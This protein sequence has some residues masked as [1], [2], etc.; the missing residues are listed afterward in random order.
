[1]IEITLFTL[2]Y[3]GL[4]G[5][6]LGVAACVGAAA[7]AEK[8]GAEL[9]MYDDPATKE[10]KCPECGEWHDK[11]GYCDYCKRQIDGQIEQALLERKW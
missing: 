7:L 5:V 2:I 4:F 11:P 8:R 3:I 9:A 1:M 10:Y 6:G